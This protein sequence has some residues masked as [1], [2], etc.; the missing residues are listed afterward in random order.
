MFDYIEVEHLNFSWCL[1]T[2]KW[3]I[4]TFP[5]VR[6]HLSIINWNL[7]FWFLNQAWLQD[8]KLGPFIDGTFKETSVEFEVLKPCTEQVIAKVGL[9]TAEDVNAAVNSSLKAADSWANLS[10]HTRACHICRWACSMERFWY[11]NWECCTYS[12]RHC[13]FIYYRQMGARGGAVGWGTALQAGWSRVRSP[14]VSLEFFV[15]IILP[16]A[17]C[18][19]GW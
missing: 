9:S 2:L 18:P 15:D 7:L 14:M 8:K 5:D 10:G 19:W 3:S 12:Q 17:L 13:S 4:L 6:P 16:G 11:Q 1:I